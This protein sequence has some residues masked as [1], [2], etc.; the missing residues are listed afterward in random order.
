M[1]GKGDDIL[2]LDF[3]EEGEDEYDEEDNPEGESDGAAEN[4]EADKRPKLE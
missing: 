4:G 2:G 3:G 1:E